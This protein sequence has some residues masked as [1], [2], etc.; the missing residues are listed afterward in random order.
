MT[1]NIPQNLKSICLESKNRNIPRNELATPKD[2]VKTYGET[3]VNK[4][5]RYKAEMYRKNHPKSLYEE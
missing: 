5:A 1:D 3:K 2:L 4:Q